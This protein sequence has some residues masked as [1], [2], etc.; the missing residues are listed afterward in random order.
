MFFRPAKFIMNITLLREACHSDSGLRAVVQG[1]YEPQTYL[2]VRHA[3]EAF[4]DQLVRLGVPR[5]AFH[6]VTLSCLVG[7]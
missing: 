7:Q 4:I 5:L 6:D 2:S 1:A 3:D